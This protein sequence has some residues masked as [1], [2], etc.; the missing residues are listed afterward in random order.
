DFNV[1]RDR[2][3]E[4]AVALLASDAAAASATDRLADWGAWAHAP[5]ALAAADRSSDPDPLRRRSFQ[6]A[7]TRFALL[8]TAASRS[9]AAG[10]FCQDWLRETARTD[11]DLIRRARR[12]AGR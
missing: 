3:C 5:K 7:A 9:G 11:P 12:I 8:C 4:F 2:L 6:L 1:D 10:S